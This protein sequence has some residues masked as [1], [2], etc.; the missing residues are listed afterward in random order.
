MSGISVRD[1]LNTH[2]TWHNG[3]ASV[4]AFGASSAFL[5]LMKRHALIPQSL[6]HQNRIRVDYA[7]TAATGD[8]EVI[9]TPRALIDRIQLVSN[10]P[11]RW[12]IEGAPVN[13]WKTPFFLSF[14]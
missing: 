3:R 8:P 11:S 6:H 5:E 10:H 12:N 2:F 14:P 7:V 13:M 1:R 4:H 9:A